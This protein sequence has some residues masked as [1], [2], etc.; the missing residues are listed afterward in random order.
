MT[1]LIFFDLIHSQ[2][3]EIY[4]PN[5]NIA[6]MLGSFNWENFTLNLSLIY[7]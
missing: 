1:G 5:T 4:Q 3:R 2:S 7:L 6:K